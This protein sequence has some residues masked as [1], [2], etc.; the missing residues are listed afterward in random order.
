MAAALVLTGGVALHTTLLA[1]GRVADAARVFSSKSRDWPQHLQWAEVDAVLAGAAEAGARGLSS[2][3]RRPGADAV[4]A[5]D[6]ASGAGTEAAACFSCVG[7]PGTTWVLG[8]GLRDFRR[9]SVLSKIC[10]FLAAS[11]SPILATN[12]VC[13]L[14]ISAVFARRSG[15]RGSTSPGFA[16]FR[17][18]ASKS[19]KLAKEPSTQRN[20]EPV[21]G[22]VAAADMDE[23]N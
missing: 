11:F 12:S 6:S 13:A 2:L 8:A 7:E 16:R 19:A 23:I 20:G 21:F 4:A 22:D 1:E 5:G 10:P 9:S 3:W 15:A 14:T 17:K 18:K